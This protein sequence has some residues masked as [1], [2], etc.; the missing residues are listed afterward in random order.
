VYTALAECYDAWDALDLSKAK[1]K[2]DSV[3]EAVKAMQDVDKGDEALE[4]M[5]SSAVDPL[6]KV[7]LVRQGSNSSVAD[8]P[9]VMLKHH[10]EALKSLM[11]W[12]TE[13]TTSE[14]AA[15]GKRQKGAQGGKG[16][17]GENGCW[18]EKQKKNSMLMKLRKCTVPGRNGQQDFDKCRSFFHIGFLFLEGSKR[19]QRRGK[20]DTASLFLYRLLEWVAQ[21][22]LAA[23]HGVFADITGSAGA[24]K[25][26]VWETGLKGEWVNAR[27]AKVKNDEDPEDLETLQQ[28]RH[29][30]VKALTGAE[31]AFHKLYEKSKKSSGS[32]FADS[33]ARPTFPKPESKQ[34]DPE[35]KE[36]DE[37][38][39]AKELEMEN[40]MLTRF[41]A[42]CK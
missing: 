30:R 19:M 2:L 4:G 29:M 9:L 12:I 35:L 34:N 32:K 16:V 37:Q 26:F 22:R 27:H 18:T 13:E 20:Y 42:E 28:K 17:K 31:T 41:I 6:A 38:I 14:D 11:E 7:D 5:F 40:E 24:Y 25:Q 23:K 10:A 39:A 21:Y 15:G 36:I 1:E 8:D 3:F 33:K